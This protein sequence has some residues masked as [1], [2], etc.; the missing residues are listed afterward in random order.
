MALKVGQ[1][2]KSVS[3]GKGRLQ[4]MLES[5]AIW[6]WR[7]RKGIWAERMS[8]VDM[9]LRLCTVRTIVGPADKIFYLF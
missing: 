3:A 8:S 5:A 6:V 7:E 4:R 2:R 9:R 1:R